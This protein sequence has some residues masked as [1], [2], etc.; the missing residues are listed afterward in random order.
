[1]NTALLMLL[2]L[3]G[4]AGA[5]NTTAATAL[6]LGAFP[7]SVTQANS[8]AEPVR[9]YKFT[10][11]A[12]DVIGL[13]IT[14]NNNQHDF[15][16][17]SDAGVTRY[18]SAAEG[19]GEIEGQHQ[20]F[21]VPILTQGA[22]YWIRAFNLVANGVTSLTL[23]GYVLP[24][25]SLDGG[26]VVV[27]DDTHNFPAV[28]LDPVTGV[29]RN[30]ITAVP[31]SEVGASLP[32]G[33]S[34]SYARST[35]SGVATG[36]E[37]DAILVNRAAFVATVDE[38]FSLTSYPLISP[39]VS[40]LTFWVAQTDA[41]GTAFILKKVDLTGAVVRAIGP[42][43]VSGFV[44][45]RG[46]AVN[47]AET[48]AYLSRFENGSPI[49]RF[50]LSSETFLSPLVAGVGGTT[51][52]LDLLILPDDSVIVP[53]SVGGVDVVRRYSAA[54]A[55]LNTYTL[56]L[57]VN[58]DLNHL[59]D[60]HDDG[61]SFWVWIFDQ[62][63]DGNPTGKFRR[64]D[65]ATG[66]TLVELSSY[67]FNQGQGP[68]DGAAVSTVTSGHSNSCPFW[69]LVPG[70]AAPEPEPVCIPDRPSVSCLA[71]LRPSVACLAPHDINKQ[72]VRLL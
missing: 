66:A 53:F 1:M 62:D 59:A 68:S 2:L 37:D 20:P 25:L 12:L 57:S 22:T 42:I 69:V 54:G 49:Y 43:T 52:L 65:V 47:A 58:Q 64:I 3:D 27:P 21:Q 32:N 35:N 33:Y 8:P 16:M 55:L 17:Y 26:G 71:P 60:A 7:F 72:Q 50:D 5:P 29:V 38:V 13:R 70:V 6:D 45:L 31:A 23:T 48:I 44:T 61:V 28:V 40:T 24:A 14:S 10:A 36:D 18:M 19:G 34:L 41:F 9:W 63:G 11:P 15:E 30:Y 51:P 4:A 39:H 46:L 67:E 56:S